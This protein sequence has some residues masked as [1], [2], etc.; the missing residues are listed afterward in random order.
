MIKYY[1][2]RCEKEFANDGICVPIYAQDAFGVKLVHLN[3]KHL[4]PECAKKFN[5]IKGRLDDVDDFFTMSNEDISLMEYD[6]KIGDQIITDIGEVGYIESICD[7]EKC[8]ERGFYEPRVITLIGADRIYITDTDKENNF[9]SF[10][11]IG[12]YTFGNLNRDLLER[13]IRTQ[14]EYVDEKMNELDMYY[15]QLDMIE[16][17]S[18]Q[19]EV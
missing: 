7:C 13:L 12:K 11:K 14:K 4:C 1:C 15:K 5:T 17:I 10:Y 18:G 16:Y 8:K 6:F 19:K 3:D 9:S 2:D